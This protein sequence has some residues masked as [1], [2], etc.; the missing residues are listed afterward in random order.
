MNQIAG[1][2]LTLGNAALEQLHGLTQL[3]TL[4]LRGTEVTDAGLEHFIWWPRLRAID[5]RGTYVSDEGIRDI[6]QALPYC[7][8]GYCQ[9]DCHR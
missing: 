1:A 8:I 4:E 5:L 3:R 6:K 2:M 9:R 7:R